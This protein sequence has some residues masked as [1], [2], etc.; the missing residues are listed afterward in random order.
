MRLIKTHKGYFI[1]KKSG[2]A[3]FVFSSV[4]QQNF[5]PIKTL[6]SAEIFIDNLIA[7]DL[8]K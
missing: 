3:Y 4:C 1:R 7:K 8:T 2:N 5:D 6:P